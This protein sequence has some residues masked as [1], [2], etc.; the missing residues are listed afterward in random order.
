MEHRKDHDHPPPP[1]G[2]RRAAGPRHNYLRDWV[3]GGIDGAVT[4]VAVVA[5]VTGASLSPGVVVVLGVANLGADGFSMAA[6][7]LLATKAEQE[8]I[9]HLTAVENRHV[10]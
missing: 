3:Y 2:A 8:D 1:A 5:G 9:E 6:S 10:D 4:T 7:N